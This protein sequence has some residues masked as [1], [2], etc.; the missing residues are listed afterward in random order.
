MP[1]FQPFH[2]D[3]AIADAT[4]ET[5]CE[6]GIRVLQGAL[7]AF[8]LTGFGH[9]RSCSLQTMHHSVSTACHL[10]RVMLT[11][12]C[13]CAG[14][15]DGPDTSGMASCSLRESCAEGT[16]AGTQPQGCALQARACLGSMEG[17]FCRQEGRQGHCGCLQQA[18]CCLMHHKERT[19]CLA[20]CQRLSPHQS[21]ITAQLLSEAW[22]RNELSIWSQMISLR[23]IYQ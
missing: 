22:C 9:Q 18:R 3:E 14:Q 11:E 17:L 12:G 20:M 2:L 13:E 19:A 1:H 21:S 5:S 6:E 7:V 15:A 16:A 10:S 8:L 23:A 4:A